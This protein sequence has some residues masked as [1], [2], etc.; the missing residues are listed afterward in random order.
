MRADEGAQPVAGLG[1][2]LT[3]GA[4]GGDLIPG[5]ASPGGRYLGQYLGVTVQIRLRD[6]PVCHVVPPVI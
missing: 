6:F 4:A 5:E 1:G 3:E 2:L